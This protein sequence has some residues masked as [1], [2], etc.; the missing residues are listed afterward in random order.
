MRTG[1]KVAVALGA[2]AVAVGAPVAFV[3]H[4]AGAPGRADSADAWWERLR[5][6]PSLVLAS[7]ERDSA[8]RVGGQPVGHLLLTARRTETR[9]LPT[10]SPVVAIAPLGDWVA[11]ATFDDGA[12][13]IEE[14][15][16][17]QR[18]KGVNAVNALAWI[19]PDLVIASDDGVYV[20]VPGQ[21][22]KIASGPFSAIGRVDR[23]WYLAGRSGVLRLSPAKGEIGPWVK[24]PAV[25]VAQPTSVGMCGAHQL[26]VGAVDGL[27]KYRVDAADGHLTEIESAGALPE[28]F[29]TAVSSG[30]EQWTPDWNGVVWDPWAGTSGGGLVRLGDPPMAPADGLPEGRISPRALDV[31]EDLA[32]AGTPRGLLVAHARSAALVPVGGPVSAVAAAGR[33]EAWCGLPGQVVLVHV[34]LLPEGAMPPDPVDPMEPLAQSWRMP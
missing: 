12:F 2:A 8:V 7:P 4:G 25:R 29:V 6:A 22:K 10:R 28:P 19:G 9:A 14:D 34:D 27:R 16:K 15:G 33:G 5:R 23:W 30:S 3:A 1:A 26:C 18:V 11:V 21:V 24:E 31:Y 13:V 17:A 32:F 20:S